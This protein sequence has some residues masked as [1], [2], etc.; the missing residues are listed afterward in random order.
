MTESRSIS[1]AESAMTKNDK[2]RAQLTG[3]YKSCIR[4]SD[5][6]GIAIKGIQSKAEFL[7]ATLQGD[8]E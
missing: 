8:Q 4:V 6:V 7:W 2:K 3:L 1:I 5:K